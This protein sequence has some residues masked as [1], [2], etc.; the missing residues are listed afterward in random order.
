MSVIW[1]LCTNT[2][3]EAVI[4]VGGSVVRTAR[5]AGPYG[6][7]LNG[8]HLSLELIQGKTWMELVLYRSRMPHYVDLCLPAATPVSCSPEVAR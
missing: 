3:I 5:V 6:H 8:A 1:A 7:R 4:K 2:R